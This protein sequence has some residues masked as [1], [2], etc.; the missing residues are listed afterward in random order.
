M[1]ESPVEPNHSRG[2]LLQATSLF[3]WDE[4]PMA[5]RAAI[6]CTDDLLRR[7]TDRDILFGGK[8]MI[9]VGDF[10]QT[11]PVVR[12]GTRQMVVDASIRSWPFWNEVAIRRLTIPIR[13]AQDPE[14]AEWVDLVGDGAGPVVQIPPFVNSVTDRDHLV[15]FTFPL[16]VLTDPESSVRRSIL[17]P[18]NDQVDAYNSLILQLMDGE[19]RIYMAADSI[20]E[21][22][23]VEG[24]PPEAFSAVLDYVARRPPPGIP[25]HNLTV[26]MGAV[27]RL[28]RNLS[29]DRGLV[30]NVRGVVRALGNRIVTLQMLRENGL[31]IEEDDTVI[32]PRIP[33]EQRLLSGHTLRRRQFPIAPAY[34]TTFNS[35]QG[36]T[37][38]HVGVDL[39]KDVF[40]HGQ[41]YTALSRVRSRDDIL[42]RVTP[43]TNTI[44]N[45]TYQE[46]LL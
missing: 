15:R 42:L 41:L 36:L 20:K 5:N 28:M 27:Y 44:H 33:F 30:K 14:Y 37:L 7:M 29:P 1:L 26:K 40:S 35:C 24:L 2:E 46:I 19:S 11:C 4:A 22:D 31:G 17:A 21:G 45:I 16:Q 25:A 3:I 10:R 23:G 34:A 18:T 39:T 12:G 38:D 32:L 13:N 8:V 6:A 43:G 9:F